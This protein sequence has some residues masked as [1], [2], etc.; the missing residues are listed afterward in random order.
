ML[1]IREIRINRI[2]CKFMLFP[3]LC[4]F[5]LVNG[6]SR[7][8]RGVFAEVEDTPERSRYGEAMCSN[9]TQFSWSECT[10]KWMCTYRNNIKCKILRRCCIAY[11]EFSEKWVLCADLM[12]VSLLTIMLKTNEN[13]SSGCCSA[14]FSTEAKKW[15]VAATLS[16]LDCLIFSITLYILVLLCGANVIAASS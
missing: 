13:E 1:K 9:L 6:R 8:V 5:I 15:P 14:C 4:H 2:Y 10:V 11:V 16:R 12:N 3:N 7:S